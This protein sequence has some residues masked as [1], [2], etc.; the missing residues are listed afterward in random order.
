MAIKEV[1]EAIHYRFER[2]LDSERQG[3]RKNQYP[4]CKPK[5]TGVISLGLFYIYIYL[6]RTHLLIL[7]AFPAPKSFGGLRSFRDHGQ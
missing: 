6:V 4:L 7:F 2:E 3:H 5:P 1:V